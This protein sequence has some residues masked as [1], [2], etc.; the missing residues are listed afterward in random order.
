M[1]CKTMIQGAGVSACLVVLAAGAALAQEVPEVQ[2]VDELR[3]P[4]FFAP[5]GSNTDGAI[6][7]HFTRS[8]PGR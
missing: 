2:A 1:L 4:T 5:P 7:M 6:M 3:P 8:A